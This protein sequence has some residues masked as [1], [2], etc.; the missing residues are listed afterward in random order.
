MNEAS[1]AD[2]WLII[3]LQRGWKRGFDPWFRRSPGERNGN[4]LQYSYLGNPMDRGAWQAMVHRVAKSW[5]WF[6]NW[7]T[8]NYEYLPLN[9]TKFEITS[10]HP[11]PSPPATHTSEVFPRYHC[12]L[13]Y[14]RNYFYSVCSKF[15][16]NLLEMSQKF[17]W[18]H[19]EANKLT[20]TFYN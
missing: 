12:S 10:T 6:S 20:K 8:T 7:T 19:R 3:H 17:I 5:T 2:Q 16:C 18:L 13:D 15:Y 11:L 9:L 1:Q 4:P 14:G